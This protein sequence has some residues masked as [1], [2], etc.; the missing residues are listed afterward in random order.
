[1]LYF[2][3]LFNSS[4]IFNIT[5]ELNFYVRKSYAIAKYFIQLVHCT[6][7]SNVQSE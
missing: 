4:T 2:I 5:L 6:I 1:M 7:Y 3:V